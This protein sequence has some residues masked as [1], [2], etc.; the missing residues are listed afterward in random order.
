MSLEEFLKK[1]Q[2]SLARKNELLREFFGCLSRAF[3]YLHETK[4]RHRDIKPANILIYQ[5]KV[6]VADFGLSLD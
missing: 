5:D 2:D 1:E 3:Q 4:I 6:K